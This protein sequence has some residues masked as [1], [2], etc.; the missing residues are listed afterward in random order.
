MASWI[1]GPNQLC[2]PANQN[3]KPQP[4]SPH[5]AAIAD[6]VEEKP[7]RTRRTKKIED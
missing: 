5:Q 3:R 4:E 6:P 2:W 1:P 7:K